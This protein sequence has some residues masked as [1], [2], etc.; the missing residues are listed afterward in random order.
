MHDINNAKH[1]YQSRIITRQSYTM[2]Q[3]TTLNACTHDSRTH[4]YTYLFCRTELSR[5]LHTTIVAMPHIMWRSSAVQLFQISEMISSRRCSPYNRT[6]TQ[7]HA[8]VCSSAIVCAQRHNQS[9]AV[10]I[11]CL[12]RSNADL[13]LFWLNVKTMTMTRRWF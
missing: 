1:G 4:T 7:T 12:S 8:P 10:L 9:E 11:L 3:G 5:P 6:D 2:T 13:Q